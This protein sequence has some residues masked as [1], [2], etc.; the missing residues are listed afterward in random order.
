MQLTSVE[1]QLD[2]QID[3]MTWFGVAPATT[4]QEFV[5]A[6]VAETKAQ[7]EDE[8]MFVVTTLEGTRLAAFPSRAEAQEYIDEDNGCWQQ[9]ADW[10][11]IENLPSDEDL[12]YSINS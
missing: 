6:L 11:Y 8:R 12:Y 9:S 3:I 7:P 1:D 10:M 4:V 5:S 2:T